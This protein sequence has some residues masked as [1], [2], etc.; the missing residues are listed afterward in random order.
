M[1]QQYHQINH[2]YKDL[3]DQNQVHHL[4]QYQK[5]MVMVLIVKHQSLPD[6]NQQ[7]AMTVVSTTLVT[8]VKVILMDQVE[9]TMVDLTVKH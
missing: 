9:H 5:C 8:A 7:G 4:L 2:Q 3:K 6:L 1:V